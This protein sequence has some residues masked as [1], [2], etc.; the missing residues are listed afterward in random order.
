MSTMA[1]SLT[2]VPVAPV[3]MRPSTF[4]SAW[5]ESLSCSTSAVRRPS[6]RSFYSVSPSTRPPAASVGPSVPS[7]PKEKTAVSFRPEMPG[8]AASAS[9]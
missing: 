3:T 2:F 1:R 9:S 5:Y 7:E 8:A 6:A 4:S